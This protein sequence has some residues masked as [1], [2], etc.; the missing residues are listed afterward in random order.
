MVEG[1]LPSCKADQVL[2]TVRVTQATRPKLI[3][4]VREALT[5]RS[6]LLVMLS[7][8]DKK[9][10]LE[11]IWWFFSV[12]DSKEQGTSKSEQPTP[13]T[14]DDSRDLQAAIE[15]SLQDTNAASSFSVLQPSKFQIHEFKLYDDQKCFEIF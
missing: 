10:S 8:V 7:S 2:S 12:Q 11:S 1:K 6:K 9:G 3:S 13:T 4:E 5:V 15:R 14:D